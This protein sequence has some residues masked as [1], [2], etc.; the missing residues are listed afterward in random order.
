MRKRIALGI[1]KFQVKKSKVRIQNKNEDTK[2]SKREIGYSDVLAKQMRIVENIK[3]SYK[4]CWRGSLKE[5]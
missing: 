1:E 2:E 4:W 3:G 5:Y